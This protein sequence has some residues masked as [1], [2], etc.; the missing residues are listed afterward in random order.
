[1]SH[2]AD[3][4]AL[5]TRLV[6]GEL[7][8]DAP[9][10]RAV[11]ETCPSCRDQ[12]AQL[13]QLARRLDAAGA[14]ERSVLAEIETQSISPAQEERIRATV[15]AQRR[16]ARRLAWPI[17]VAAAVL[18]LVGV[19]AWRQWRGNERIEE[20]YLGSQNFS[21]LELRTAADGAV[22]FVWSYTGLPPEGSYTLRVWDDSATGSQPTVFDHLPDPP[23][24]PT[25]EQRAKLPQRMRWEVEVFDATGQSLGYSESRVDTLRQ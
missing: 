9:E 21:G 20:R 7:A 23:W 18:A 24:T 19:I 1:M 14:E 25:P 4:D 15:L 3:H 2:S 17:A 6:V 12:W 10:A 22:S 5:L 11:L 8:P 13:G 16:S